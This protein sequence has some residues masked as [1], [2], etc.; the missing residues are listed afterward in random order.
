MVPVEIGARDSVQGIGMA[1]DGEY[2]VKG[3][4]RLVGVTES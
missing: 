1:F 2:I 3:K 4:C